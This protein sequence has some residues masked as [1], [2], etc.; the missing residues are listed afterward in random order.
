VLEL[1]A[2][3][4]EWLG[5]VPLTIL[6]LENE[7]PGPVALIET[8]GERGS[9]AFSTLLQP[10]TLAGLERLTTFAGQRRPLLWWTTRAESSLVQ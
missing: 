9:L 7:K 3:V 4:G 8:L 2:S 5:G 10:I 6:D 1:V